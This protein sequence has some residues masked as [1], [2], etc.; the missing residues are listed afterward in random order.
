MLPISIRVNSEAAGNIVAHDEHADADRRVD[1]TFTFD[2]TFKNDTAQDVTV[3]A[4]AAGDRPGWT[5]DD[6]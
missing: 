5:I 6:R 3:S 4:T 2:L 1:T